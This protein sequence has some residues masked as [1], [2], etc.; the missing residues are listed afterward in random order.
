MQRPHGGTEHLVGAGLSAQEVLFLE[1]A[2]EGHL[3]I[4]DRPVPGDFKPEGGA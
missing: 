4:E 3:G 2:L 1:R